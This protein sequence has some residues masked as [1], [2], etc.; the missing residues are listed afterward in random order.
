MIVNIPI[1]P[2]SCQV[3]TRASGTWQS[4]L[5]TNYSVTASHLAMHSTLLLL[6]YSPINAH[7]LLHPHQVK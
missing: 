3:L 1:G 7:Q 5:A 2:L 6:H 4:L